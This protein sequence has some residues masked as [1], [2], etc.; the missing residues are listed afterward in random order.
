M[1]SEPL[2]CGYSGLK[3]LVCAKTS[4]SAVTEVAA[5]EHRDLLKQASSVRTP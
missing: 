3:V 4:I 2:Y 5:A 1:F